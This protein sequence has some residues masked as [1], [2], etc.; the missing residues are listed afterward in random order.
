MNWESLYDL[1]FNCIFGIV[2]SV[3]ISRVFLIYQDLKDDYRSVIQGINVISEMFSYVEFYN[4]PDLARAFSFRD[5]EDYEVK[6]A[7]LNSICKTAQEEAHRLDNMDH[8]LSGE[9]RTITKEYKNV[10][11]DILQYS[12]LNRKDPNCD[13]INTIE[14][15]LLTLKSMLIKYNKY[16][17]NLI[18][19]TFTRA[20]K[21][22]LNII[23]ISIILVTVFIPVI[24]TI[25]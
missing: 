1:F 8:L 13:R 21:D 23:M 19:L 16:R 22:K 24:L 3:I 10:L 6:E 25:L 4:D 2:S 12:D 17:E 15:Y 18:N 14:Q 11:F 9:I 5:A 7:A 20:V